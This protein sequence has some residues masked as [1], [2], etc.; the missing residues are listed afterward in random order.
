MYYKTGIIAE[1]PEFINTKEVRYKW[2]LYSRLNGT[3]I[4]KSSNSF[5]TR[6]GAEKSLKKFI[7]NV[8]KTV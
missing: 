7:E 6:E 3:Y 5:K 4:C 2:V 8:T 1:F